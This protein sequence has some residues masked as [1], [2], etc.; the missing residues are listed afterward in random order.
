[1]NLNPSGSLEEQIAE[2]RSH[3]RGLEEALLRRGIL[4][5]GDVAPEAAGPVS[6]QLTSPHEAEQEQLPAADGHPP[7]QI[8]ENPAPSFSH[9]TDTAPELNHSL[10][11]RI[12]SQWFNRIGILALLIGM[13]WFLKLAI[14]NHWIGPLGR[15][16]I[17]LVAGGGLIAW[18]ERFD[19]RGYALF[20]YSLKAVGSGILYL[21][22]WAAF[23]LFH[24]IPSGVAFALMILVTAFNAFMAWIKN[25][26]L[27]ALYAIVGGLSTPLLLSTGGNHEVA[28]FSYLLMLNI[29]T[30][31]LVILR[32][33]S[34]L[35]FGAFTGTVIFFA[36]W[37]IEFYARDEFAITA[38]FLTCFFLIFAFAPRMVLVDLKSEARPSRWHSLALVVMPI[39]NAAL[40]FL[41][42]YGLCDSVSPEWGGPCI[43][44]AL[45][46][47]YLALLRI[48]TR[49]VLRDSSGLLS[50]L[51]LTFAI[52]CLTIAIPLKA[53][54]RWLTAG[55]LIEGVALLWMAS[56]QRSLLL[57][58]L[59]LLCLPLGLIALLSIDTPVSLTPIFNARFAIYCTAIA[60]FALAAWIARSD[61][62]FGHEDPQYPLTWIRIAAASAL[63]VNALILLMLSLEIHA[64]WWAEPS[65]ADWVQ[66]GQ[67]R[68]YAQFSYS[69]LFMIFGAILLG[70]GFWKRTAFLRWQALVLLAAAI[71]K[72][73]LF[74]VSELSQG[75]RV[76]S[77]LGLGALLLAI[78]FAYQKD[79]LG[80][81]NPERHTS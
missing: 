65:R 81:R 16:F 51:H 2:L 75:Y 70:I 12:G 10:E 52:V 37:W 33:W 72:V 39:A 8:A 21:S 48:P 40:G 49:G 59:A 57:R 25:A 67:H 5:Q 4:A 27:L 60:T 7:L 36:G 19:R 62:D 6:A 17:G 76:L 61:R 47:F 71:G 15:V 43:A 38:F 41:A 45:A 34:R 46:A 80:L 79:W 32:P 30:L 74:D 22:L 56:R 28:L 77:F 63:I 29:A 14:D 31:V 35:L 50:S 73:F 58:V 66:L 44:V 64:Y 78:S 11:N 26:E 3:L 68:M 24:L 18:S 20:G 55:W 1:M 9:S 54:G 23:S 13:A 69:A 42:F 53:H